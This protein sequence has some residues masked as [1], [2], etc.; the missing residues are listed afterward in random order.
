MSIDG[1]IIAYFVIQTIFINK[2]YGFTLLLL[3]LLLLCCFC[4]TTAD[5][6][7]IFGTKAFLQEYNSNAYLACKSFQKRQFPFE[8]FV[9][10]NLIFSNV[11]HWLFATKYWTLSL[12][13]EMIKT[14][15]DIT[16]H[17]KKSALVFWI[18]FVFCIISAILMGYQFNLKPGLKPTNII[19]LI[20]EL[21]PLTTCFFLYNALMRINRVNPPHKIIDTV[22]VYKL[23]TVY[24]FFCLAIFFQCIGHLIKQQF[25][26]L[27]ISVLFV[28]FISMFIS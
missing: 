3:S 5:L 4:S 16:K 2:V 25:S 18:G 15:S 19:I 26:S 11:T 17:D 22:E 1:V 28:V 7:Y 10:L 27:N 21:I 14:S 6:L 24:G 9:S 12:K 23:I 8:I 13:L 20:F